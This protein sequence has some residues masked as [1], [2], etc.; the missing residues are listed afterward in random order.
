MLKK[1]LHYISHWED[2]H[3]FAKYIPIAPVWLW[4]CLRSG[5][6][7]FFTPSNPSLT[8][9]GFLGETKREMYEQL[10]PSTYP[11]SIYISPSLSFIEVED[12]FEASKLNYPVAVKPDAGMMGF[13]FRKINNA[14]ELHQYHGVMP[15]DYIIQELIDLPVEVSVFYYRYPDQASGTITGFLKKEFLEV[16]GDGRTTLAELISNYPRVMFRHEEMFRK[17]ESKLADIIQ[18]GERYCLSYALNLSR[19]G[20]LIN[21]EHEKDDDLL[22][23]FDELSHYT[24]TFYYGRYDIKCASVE[25]LK[26]DRNYSILEYNGSGAEPHHVYGNRNSLFQAYKI[27]LH[28]WKVLYEISRSNRRKG[29]KYWS[30]KAGAR[31]SKKAK[32]HFRVLKQLDTQFEFT[33]LSIPKSQAA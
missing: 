31:F 7:W 21:L 32:L 9:G 17:H 28:H 24:G 3:W 2:W 12:L 26:S 22:R 16:V 29:I 15:C 14:D 27:L 11:F 13:M 33:S 5:S 19:G 10:P 23:V 30:Y 25:D 18:E 8:F 6:F 1:A 4:H 20:K